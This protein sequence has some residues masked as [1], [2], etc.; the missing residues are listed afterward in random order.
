MPARTLALSAAIYAG[1]SLALARGVAD[2]AASPLASAT[3]RRVEA[4]VT[5]VTRSALID[6]DIDRL[7]ADLT[8]SFV[9]AAAGG[10]PDLRLNS[11]PIS[12]E[13]LDN[14]V[15]FEI[16]RADSSWEPF[17][18]GV[19]N[20][21]RFRGSL[22]LRVFEIAASAPIVGAPGV[23]GITDSMV[24]L[25][26]APDALPRL[27]ISELRPIM[28]FDLSGGDVAGAWSGQTPYPFPTMRDGAVEVVSRLMISPVELAIADRGIAAD[29]STVWGGDELV[30]F[31]RLPAPPLKVERS[32][33]GLIIITLVPAPPENPRLV[34][35]GTIAVH[36]TGW[37]TDGT[38]F[39]SSRQPN[40]KAFTTRIPSGFIR[41]WN[42]GLAGMANGERRRLVIPPDLAFGSRG[43]RGIPPD[44]TLIFDVECVHVDNTVPPE[45]TQP[46]T[47]P[48]QIVNPHTFQPPPQPPPSVNPK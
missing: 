14:A 16:A 48:S 11:A 3:A 33:D 32:G 47:N 36:F 8:G 40:R 27:A 41:G 17:R 10:Y 39:D 5:A 46:T 45:L 26:A 15:Y 30:R 4:P 21:H 6:P 35:N 20:V 34:E 44:S 18:Q 1:S 12:V 37:L 24:G 42:E 22:R 43:N 2:P 23:T 13:G 9:A 31:R 28:V 25:W 19:F 38:R 7:I 29:G